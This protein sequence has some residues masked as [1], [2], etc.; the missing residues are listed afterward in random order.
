MYRT[1]F[2]II[3]SEIQKLQYGAIDCL[4][5]IMKLGFTQPPSP[6]TPVPH[7]LRNE[8]LHACQHHI[9]QYHNVPPTVIGI[10]LP[11]FPL[12]EDFHIQKTHE[13]VKNQVYL[14]LINSII[15]CIKACEERDCENVSQV[16]LKPLLHAIIT[17]ELPDPLPQC[18]FQ[19]LS[20]LLLPLL[21]YTIRSNFKHPSACLV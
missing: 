20:K 5:I 19:V 3:V 8:F 16:F 4:A 1:N 2:H 18:C 21:C 17:P 14:G 11:P 13:K 10:A 15:N 6:T 12:E 9:T 7:T